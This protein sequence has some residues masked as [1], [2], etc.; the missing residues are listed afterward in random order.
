MKIASKMNT[1][2]KPKTTSYFGHCAQPEL[3]QP[4][5]CLFSYV[6]QR[7]IKKSKLIEHLLRPIQSRTVLTRLSIW[8][9]GA[10]QIVVSFQCQAGAVAW[11]HISSHWFVHNIIIDLL[12]NSLK[13]VDIPGGLIDYSMFKSLVNNPILYKQI[14][15]KVFLG[16]NAPLQ[17]ASVVNK[18]K[19]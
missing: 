1:I 16:A 11:H 5:L 2:S 3:T 17:L 12:Y 8:L 4:W 10:V 15:N 14:L 19:T 7:R 18:R 9:N 13:N 6:W